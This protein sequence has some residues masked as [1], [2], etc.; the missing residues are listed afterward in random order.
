ML[1]SQRRQTVVAGQRVIG[2]D[3][4]WRLVPQ[5]G[6]KLVLVCCFRGDELEARLAEFMGD[7][8]GVGYDAT[9]TFLRDN[10]PI[11]ADLLKQIKAK[12]AE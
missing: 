5:S 7:Q 2:Q 3:H 11:A 8:L 12:L 9:R 6:Q 1:D 10:K 4:V